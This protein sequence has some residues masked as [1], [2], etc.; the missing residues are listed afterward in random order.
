MTKRIPFLASA[1]ILAFITL[2]PARPAFSQNQDVFVEDVEIRGNRRIPKE[3]ILYYVQ[4]K[5]QDRFDQNLANRDLQAI[6]QMGLFDPLGTKLYIEDGPRGGKIIIFQVK[7]YPLIRDL[8][9]RGMKSATESE[10]L[11]RFKERR[12]QIS[13][14]SQ[15]DPA[16]AN[17][18]RLVLKELLAE[19]GHPNA[20]VQIEVEDISATTV[21]LI[22]N[23]DEGPRVRVKEIE[24]TGDRDGFSQ[25][26]LR[27]AMK[28]VKEAGL[29]STFTS[30]DIYFREKLLDDIERVRFFLGTK[31]YL[32][33]KI[34][35]PVVE[36]AG[37]VSGGFPLPIPGL[38]KSGPGKKISIPVEVGRRYKITKVE[39]KGVTI[40]QPG[41]I[42]AVSGLKE[43][44]YVDA[45][46]IQENVFKGIKDVY[47]TQGYIQ[48]SVDFI[49]KFTDK[50]AE[51]GEVEIMLEV[52]EGRQFTL[53]RLEFIGNTNTRDVVLRREVLLNEGDPYNKRYW[54]FSLNRLNQ[55]GLFE[56]VKEK[57]AITRTND[58]DQTVDIDLQVKERGRQE[59]Q[60]N[61]GV[62]GFAGSFFGITYST[63]NLLGYGESL[64]LALSGGNRQLS[65]QFGFT[66]PYLFGK[67]IQLGFQLFTSKYQYIGQGFNFAQA[68][69]ILQ[70]SFFGLSS[71]NADTLFTQRTTGGSVSVSAPLALFTKKFP[72]FARSTRFGLSYSLATNSIQDPK[73]NRDA[74][75]K[76]DI[77]VT[78]SQPRILTSRV[79]PNIYYNTKNGTLDPTNGQSLF[80]GFSLSGGILGGDVN[81][82]A[83]SLEYQYFKPV[84]RRRTEKP[85]VV[86]MRLRADHIRTFGTP[87]T[88]QTLSFVGGI[89]LYERFYLGGEYDI[90]GYNFRSISPVV[91]ADSFLST[92]NVVAK[93]TDPADST[94]LIDA[95]AGT[96]AQSVIR[97]YTFEAPEGNCNEQPSSA[98]NVLKARRFFTPI[99]GD[100]QFIYNLEYRIPVFSVL[101]IAAFTDVGTSFNAR[102]Y[103]DQLST[104]NFINQ[105]ITPTGVTLNPA[106]RVATAEELASAPRDV[107][108]NAIGY[109]TIFLQG[110][111]RDYS[112]VRTSE[113]NV[114]FLSDLRSSMGL[115]FRVQLPVINVPFRLIFAYNPQAKTDITDPT[116]LFIER[117]TVMRFSVGRTF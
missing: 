108:G 90:R 73:V 104:T 100:T 113:Q 39:E 57:D 35:E 74:D 63:N 112:I 22:F 66:E 54:D 30:K 76:N 49:P 69:Q 72:T 64:S 36:D 102:K 62:S 107:L 46:K 51:E 3:S 95:P 96:V 55:L 94:K 44:D 71:V 88:T 16:K 33:A 106:G 65:A 31:G 99:G 117:R 98:C 26:R 6:L 34:G 86:A 1:L 47:G 11:T 56:E 60:L 78:F 20:Q 93:V 27:G 43:G 110:D 23:V 38:R 4:S 68:N 7:E 52:D 114:K 12:A 85:H 116:V 67:P 97:N 84:F 91:P 10:V 50:T 83:P 58:R 109:R 2:V 15:F 101:S 59:I 92:K 29:I 13:K 42:K 9:Y 24:F 111:S 17:G 45:K 87:F 61:G 37:T 103:K 8:Q 81:T 18:A 77:P 25:R 32:Q 5:P 89:P 21:A 48:A 40:F 75:P 115:E 79:T 105:T 82:F 70:A 14:E 80:L 41:I 28:L 53:R 19:K